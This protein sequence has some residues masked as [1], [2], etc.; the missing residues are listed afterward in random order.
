[1][2]NRVVHLD[3][4]LVQYYELRGWDASGV[5]TRERLQMLGLEKEGEGVI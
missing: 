3:K 1:V 2:K 4:L 5:P